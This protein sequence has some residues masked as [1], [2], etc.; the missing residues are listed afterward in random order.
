MTG[1]S[2][3]STTATG[4][5]VGS[6]LATGVYFGSTKIWPAS[7]ITFV[8][9]CTPV[10]SAVA[11]PS[12]NL[13]LPAAAQAGDVV[14]ASV[15]S[16]ADHTG[17]GT[18]ADSGPSG[19]TKF[20]ADTS[21]EYSAPNPGVGSAYA[22]PLAAAD[23]TNGYVTFTFTN[24]SALAIRGIVVRG[25]YGTILDVA[26][27]VV[28]SSTAVADPFTFTIPGITTLDD[29]C[30]LV[31]LGSIL[32]AEGTA[33]TT[34]T[35]FTV[36]DMGNDANTLQQFAYKT[37]TTHGATGDVSMTYGP[38]ATY[39]SEG[40]IGWLVALKPYVAPTIDD[41]GH[42][43][44][45]GNY[46]IATHGSSGGSGTVVGE[47]LV[48]ATVQSTV[49]S[50]TALR[51]DSG[52]H[53]IEVDVSSVVAQAS[54][55]DFTICL[56]NGSIVAMNGGT[57]WTVTVLNNCYAIRV[58]TP[59]S[60]RVMKEVSGVK[61]DLTATD[62]TIPDITANAVTLKLVVSPAGV[63]TAYVN[64]TSVFSTTDAS[65]SPDA[66]VAMVAQGR[67]SNNNGGTVNIDKIILEK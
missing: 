22:V 42:N 40:Y 49:S 56:G 67:A 52:W 47:N 39:S 45:I 17:G 51:S 4:V 25:P 3:G 26:A 20:V 30:M 24:S 31:A 6:T 2:L 46:T 9:A 53:S 19:S 18:Y 38:D 5:Y 63:V 35:G 64:G 29:G 32:S 23:I 28:K 13:G 54:F 33:I 21:F 43:N 62:I 57:A 11:V 65:V 12:L 59:T 61:T 15:I 50:V 8:A 1:L 60:L 66:M 10:S 55:G 58:L 27:S 16:L 36:A 41:F 7:A 14:L 37:Q 48:L 44:A 34:P